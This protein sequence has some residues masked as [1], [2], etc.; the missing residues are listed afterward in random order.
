MEG[1]EGRIGGRE[2]GKNRWK[3]GG[4]RE[5]EKAMALRGAKLEGK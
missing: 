3:G 4:G 1:R 2:G 5:G